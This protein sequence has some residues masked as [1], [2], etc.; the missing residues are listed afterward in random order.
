MTVPVVGALLIFS[1]M[2]GPPA[3]ARSFTHRPGLAMALSVVIAL[4]TVWVA[5]AAAY[6]YNWPVG[7]FVGMIAALSYGIGR[8]WAAWRRRQ[9]RP[10]SS[11]SLATAPR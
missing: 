11:R 7:F 1:L 4:I 3:A 8:G 10:V 6:I 5:I 9:V 2:I